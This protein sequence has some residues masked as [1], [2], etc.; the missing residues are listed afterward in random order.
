M[1]SK[2][3]ENGNKFFYQSSGS[4]TPIIFLPGILSVNKIWKKC[5]TPFFDTNKYQL[6]F[7]YYRGQDFFDAKEDFTVLDILSDLK[8]FIDSLNSKK[9]YLVGDALGASMALRY[10]L[11][12]PQQVEKAVLSSGAYI[13]DYNLFLKQRSWEDILKK[14]DLSTF[15]DAILPDLFSSQF[16]EKNQD[17]L[18]NVKEDALQ[19]KKKDSVLKLFS[20]LKSRE[21]LDYSL[22]Q[23]PLFILHGKEDHIIPI[24][25]AEELVKIIPTAQFK[26]MD[27]GHVG[28][29]EKTEQ[30]CN[31]IQ[32]F[33]S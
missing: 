12:N 15:Y 13:K 32:D 6:F 28:F 4:G 30:Y 21:T 17:L 20:A 5:L 3:L 33:F 16:A 24:K 9:I 23:T 27:S 8:Y 31:Y 1:Q 2:I 14:T 25:H 19:N 18:K 10:I 29:L 11:K 26:A 7:I 22:I